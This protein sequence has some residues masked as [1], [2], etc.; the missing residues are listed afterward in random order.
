VSLSRHFV[1]L[2]CRKQKDLS[3]SRPSSR[4]DA[5]IAKVIRSQF[6]YPT[7]HP[8]NLFPTCYISNKKVIS[9]VD[10]KIS[11]TKPINLYSR[12]VASHHVC[13][14]KINQLPGRI[15]TNS[16]F[17]SRQ[18]KSMSSLMSCRPG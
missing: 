6:L 9:M 11:C 17:A 8:D 3:L 5:S 14:V 10:E 18:Q 4:E 12:I 7:A 13:Q 15:A 2:L 16:S 1:S